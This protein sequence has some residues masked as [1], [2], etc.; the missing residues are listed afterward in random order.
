M[1]GGVNIQKR[2]TSDLLTLHSEKKTPPQSCVIYTKMLKFLTST[3]TFFRTFHL[4]TVKNKEKGSHPR[5]MVMVMITLMTSK[6][7]G[8]TNLGSVSLSCIVP[9]AE[10]VS[11][12]SLEIIHPW[13]AGRIYNACQYVQM[14]GLDASIHVRMNVHPASVVC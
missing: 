1:C 12:N 7:D 14:D 2:F 5:V 8:V 9:S 10:S 6:C 13:P 3:Q 11:V 4:T